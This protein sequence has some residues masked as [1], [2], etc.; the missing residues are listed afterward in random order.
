M[1]FADHQCSQ[2][3]FEGFLVV[4]GEKF[5]AEIEESHR[6]FLDEFYHIFSGEFLEIESSGWV[7]KHHLLN[8][9]T[10]VCQAVQQSSTVL[11]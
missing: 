8:V 3:S 5:R 6:L 7:Y 4:H 1:R 2:T 11:S 10:V 9:I